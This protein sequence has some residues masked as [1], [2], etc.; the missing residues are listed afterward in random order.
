MTDLPS[1]TLLAA[2]V[3]GVI[4]FLSLCVLPLVPGYLSYVLGRAPMETPERQS[5]EQARSAFFISLFFALGFSLVFMALGASAS[6]LGRLLVRY[7]YEANILGGTVITLFGLFLTG[8]LKPTWL[9]RDTRFQVNMEGGRAGSALVM[10]LAFAFG[11]T[12]CIGPILGAILTM[13]VVSST[14]TGGMAYL[15]IHSLGLGVPFLA[16]A[17]L[18]NQ[19]F[20]RIRLLRRLSRPLHIG[21]GIILML[22]G[23]AMITGYLTRSGLWLLEAFPWLVNIG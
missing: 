18:T 5:L 19:L 4:S 2:F 3:A 16:I 14:A 10:G 22:M 9:S 8:I 1:V 15:A 7:R 17:V 23:V 6:A 20:A 12:P 11:W 21:A 13:T